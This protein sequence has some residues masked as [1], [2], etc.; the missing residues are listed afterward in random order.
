MHGFNIEREIN[1]KTYLTQCLQ[2]AHVNNNT[3][4]KQMSEYFSTC[5][6]YGCKYHPANVKEY[7][8]CVVKA[9]TEF[10][11]CS[12]PTAANILDYMR[13]TVSFRSVE[14]LVQC[15]EMF[16]ND[17]SNNKINCLLPNGLL[18]IRNG[19]TNVKTSWRSFKAAEYTD[20]TLNLVYSDNENTPTCMIIEARFTL[21]FLWQVTQEAKDLYSILRQSDTIKAVANEVYMIDEKYEKYH[22]KINRLIE[23]GNSK[24]LTKQLLWRPNVVLSMIEKPRQYIY[25]EP[26]LSVVGARF[27]QSDANFVLFFVN[28]LMHFGL[29]LLNEPAT[30]DDDSVFLRK[31]LNYNHLNGQIVA[32]DYFFGIDARCIDSDTCVQYLIV[33][34]IMKHPCF[35][36]LS[37]I[38][39]IWV[40]VFLYCTI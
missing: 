6:A 1:T 30:S 21:D 9:S 15:L 10:D 28:C 40:C 23:T 2:F 12:F 37:Q 33:E 29:I 27:C 19:F 38:E 14:S 32:E 22:F 36:G 34:M 39:P 20:I 11:T 24:R 17:I 18:K 13:F 35:L 7:D 26:L 31:Y 16:V 25:Y 3:L 8:R 4:H 5:T